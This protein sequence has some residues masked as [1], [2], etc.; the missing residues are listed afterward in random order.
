MPT[1]DSG[2]DSD[3]TSVAGR[4]RRNRKITSTT[5]T[6]AS[7][8]SNSTSV[9]EA[10]IGVV[11]SLSTATSTEGGSVAR[12]CGS[13]CRMLRTTAI[14][15]EPGWRW[16]F[17]ITAGARPDQAASWSFSAPL[18]MVATSPRRTAWPFL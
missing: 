9:T 8:S 1:S 5:S 11:W 7:P 17:R 18:T 13:R 3:G 14:T 6:T 4:V 10:W 2:T 15:L 16:M 12:I